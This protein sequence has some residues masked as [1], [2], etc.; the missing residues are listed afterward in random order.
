MRK[1]H[2]KNSSHSKAQEWAEISSILQGKRYHLCHSATIF[3]N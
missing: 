3:N 1:K 2:K